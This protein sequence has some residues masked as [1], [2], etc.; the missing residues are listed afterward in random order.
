[1][2][3]LGPKQSTELEP[4]H[5]QVILKESSTT[6]PLE[7]AIIQQGEN[8]VEVEIRKPLVNIRRLSKC[9][10]L[11]TVFL[12]ITWVKTAKLNNNKRSYAWLPTN[13][14]SNS[15]YKFQHSYILTSHYYQPQ[16]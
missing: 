1:M 10:G 15:Y 6:V 11:D 13:P 2:E 3:K 4:L 8:S 16:P 5:T 7:L 9:L 14:V 12:A